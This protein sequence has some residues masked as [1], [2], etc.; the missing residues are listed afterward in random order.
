MN[1]IYKNIII[2][3]FINKNK[4]FNFISN[5]YLINLF[6]FKHFIFILRITYLF[7]IF[8]IKFIKYNFNFTK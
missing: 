8:I 3:T 2:F 6:Y 7:F 5:F 4:I 1:Y